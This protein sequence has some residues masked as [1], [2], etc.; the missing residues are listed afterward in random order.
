MTGEPGCVDVTLAKR[1]AGAL[2]LPHLVHRH[3]LDQLEQE[4]PVLFSHS[5]GTVD[6]ARIHRDWQAV[7][8]RRARGVEVIA[9]GAGGELLKDFYFRHEFPFYGRRPA[10]LG[11]LYDLRIAPMP[12]ADSQLTASARE[13][14]RESRAWLISR[15][16]AYRAPFNH[17]T[18]DQAFFGLRL[19]EMFGG[20]FSTYINLGVDVVA[21]LMERD[22]AVAIMALSPWSRMMEGQHRRLIDRLNPMAAALPTTSG[23]SASTASSRLARDLAAYAGNELRRLVN[24]LGQRHLGRAPL[25]RAGATSTDAPGFG[26]RLKRLPQFREGLAALQARGIYRPGLAPDAG[27][28]HE[29]GRILTLGLCFAHLDRARDA[30]THES[31]ARAVREPA[32]LRAS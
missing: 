15:L 14:V 2:G 5:D 29:V 28:R 25:P 32:V 4:L 8:A 17:Q 22:G 21:P 6:V 3:D 31:A 16:E 24:K 27:R 26:D 13:L 11:R 20:H 1:V 18:C 23:Y 7:L 30:A 19:P 9:H 10:S 12:L